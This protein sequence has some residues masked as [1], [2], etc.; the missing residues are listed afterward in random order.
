MI[1][2]REKKTPKRFLGEAN[3]YFKANVEKNLTLAFFNERRN[4]YGDKKC[5]NNF[6]NAW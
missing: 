5:K 1:N 3:L 4:K 2:M 6:Y